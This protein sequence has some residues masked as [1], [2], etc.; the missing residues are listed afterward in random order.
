MTASLAF[1]KNEAAILRGD[2]PDKYTRILPFIVGDRILEIGSAEGVLSLLIAK[3]GRDV[4][5][6]E[7]STERHEAALAL[8]AEW[9]RTDSRLQP[10]K[11]FQG[12]IRDNLFLL[13]QT[14]TLVAV[15]MI[16]Y[17]GDDIDSV[18][19][20][21]AKHVR[22]VVLCGNRNRADRWRAGKPDAPL[23]EF[24]RYSAR[25]G[26]RDLLERHGY[27]ISEEATDGDE[28]VVGVLD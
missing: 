12:D 22:T 6:L 27:R 4:A 1:R 10:V 7:R 19:A 18:F 16:Y 2:V 11:F 14:D 3:Q 26:M 17:L 24:N 5:A 23:G 20:E 21:A 28:I 25:E 13:S 8:S 15:R 9:A